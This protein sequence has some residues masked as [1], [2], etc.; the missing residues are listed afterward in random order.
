M[1]TD[2]DGKEFE[3]KILAKFHTAEYSAIAKQQGVDKTLI[4]IAKQIAKDEKLIL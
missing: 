1:N 4:G 2:D 3:K